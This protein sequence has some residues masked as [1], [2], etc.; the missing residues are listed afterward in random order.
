MVLIADTELGAL[1]GTRFPDSETLIPGQLVG[2]SAGVLALEGA[3]TIVGS[4]D[5]EL[6]NGNQGADLIQAGFG[7]DTLFGGQDNDVLE[8]EGDNDRLFGNLGED[9]LNGGDGADRLYG[10]KNND[11][12]FGN[13]GADTL[14]GDLG[15][16]TLTG[17][18]DADVFL[19]QISVG[20]ADF[21]TDFQDG[22]DL[23]KLP[24]SLEFEDLQLTDQINDQVLITIAA[25]GEEL[26]ILSGVTLPEI[27]ETD[28]ITS[29]DETVETLSSVPV[30]AI[31]NVTGSPL[32]SNPPLGTGVTGIFINQEDAVAF[33][34]NLSLN[35][36]DL[37]AL[38]QIT[39]V[40]LAEVYQMS[41]TASS[42]LE[43]D[44]IPNE[45]QVENAENI[46]GTTEFE[47]VPLFIARQNTENGGYLTIQQDGEQIIPTFFNLEDLQGML[48]NFEN[49][50]PDLIAS[51]V[52]EV[53]S[54]EALLEAF[55]TDDNIFLDRI[56]L[57]PPRETVEFLRD[58]GSPLEL[59]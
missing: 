25:T 18:A 6:I 10:G 52:T 58:S 21:I 47:G 31:T 55:T 39:P 23:I 27:T 13:F 3:D 36:P 46:L 56:T 2:F 5:N 28:F 51:V 1:L 50:Q 22:I 12:L 59:I 4:N 49:Q 33:I 19:T 24:A 42:G 53:I 32:V 30:F 8:G 43:F 29:F 45:E 54:L 34:D 41:E 48:D 57:I 40:S 11:Q 44:Y 7:I 17:G 38:L 15:A 26:A 35:Q 20:E 14:S 37:V 16:D 9:I